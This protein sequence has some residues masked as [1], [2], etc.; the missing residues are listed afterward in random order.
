MTQQSV[1]YPMLSKL[2]KKKT[3]LNSNSEHLTILIGNNSLFFATLSLLSLEQKPKHENLKFIIPPFQLDHV[4]KR[5]FKSPKPGLKPLIWGQNYYC[6]PPIAQKYIDNETNW[7]K[8]EKLTWEQYRELRNEIAGNLKKKYEVEFYYGNPYIK[9]S[10]T[11]EIVNGEDRK[12]L[13]YY[14]NTYFCEYLNDYTLLKDN[15]PRLKDFPERHEQ[16]LLVPKVE[17]ED[18]ISTKDILYGFLFEKHQRILRAT[19]NIDW[20][21]EPCAH[22]IPHFLEHAKSNRLT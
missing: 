5:H 22:H 12:T 16:T 13:H 4:H 8:E 10:K 9:D 15:K 18:F 2:F 1:L 19:K 20:S 6:L 14:Q 7:N 3:L 17:K 21:F 11:I